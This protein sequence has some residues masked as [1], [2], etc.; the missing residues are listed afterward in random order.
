MTPRLRLLLILTLALPVAAPGRAEPKTAVDVVVDFTPAGRKL[1]RPA[2]GK[3]VY[4]Y[5]LLGGY[6]AL[7]AA[8]AGDDAPPPPLEVAHLVAV[9]LAKQGYLAT[10]AVSESGHLALAPTPSLVIAVHWGRIHPI[11]DGPADP[12]VGGGIFYNQNQMLAL[13]GGASF[14]DLLLSFGREDLMRA[15]DQN[16]YFVVVTAFDF[17]AARKNH[18]R[19]Q[20]WQAK[21]SV[22]NT[23]VTLTDVLPAMVRAGGPLFGRETKQPQVLLVPLAP[24]GRVEIGNPTVT[25]GPAP[26]TPAAP[27]P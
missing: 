14:Q 19:V 13:V 21:M 16:R 10:R 20:L 11:I 23:G 15:A 24:E 7:G 25:E 6:Q 26:P 17:H 5:P 12:S 9:E 3:P 2:P 4:Y 27:S 8:A 22:P 1:D 18:Q